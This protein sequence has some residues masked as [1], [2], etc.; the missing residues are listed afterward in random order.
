M[1]NIVVG[2]LMGVAFVG[3]IVCAKKQ[4]TT[5]AAKPA[6]VGLL[7]AVVVCAIVIL[8]H[9]L[10]GGSDEEDI[11]AEVKYA[12]ST[13]YMLAKHLSQTMPGAKVLVVTDKIN[14]NSVFQQ[15][16]IKALKEGFSP[17]I[18]DVVFDVPTVNGLEEGPIS[19]MM[20]AADMDKLFAKHKDR[21]LIITLI[22][23]PTDME[24]MKIWHQFLQ[25][26]KKTPKLAIISG[27]I[28]SLGAYIQSGLIVGA[29]VIKPEYRYMDGAPIPETYEKAFEERYLLIT[30][31]NV[32][33]MSKKYS[34]MFSK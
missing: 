14:K 24:K 29:V 27:S 31:K 3:M 34:R 10:G 8:V 19:D 17:A 33:A 30:P 12:A 18:T 16:K 7:V 20:T 13:T 4:N 6:A 1:F 26:K 22:G 28:Y 11:N 15:A 25:D 32:V 21:N 23:L 9:N 5:P 2:V